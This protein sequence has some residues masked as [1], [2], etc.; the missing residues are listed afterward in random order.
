MTRTITLL[1]I[2]CTLAGF[3]C[4]QKPATPRSN[5]PA[6]AAAR[7][8][9]SQPQTE[10]HH[11]DRIELGTQ[12]VSGLTVRA[13]R[14]VGEIR[15]GGDAPIDVWLTTADGAAAQVTAVRFWIGSEDAEGSVKARAEIEDPAE[16]SHW[17]T[18]AEIPSTLGDDAQLWVEIER[19]G[20]K[21]ATSFPLKRE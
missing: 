18:H 11:G 6:D 21:Q 19:E 13:A 17:H 12:E 7:P 10:G 4:E 9:G 2:G 15:A 16:P 1:L 8:A 14:D 20:E 5:P 3:A